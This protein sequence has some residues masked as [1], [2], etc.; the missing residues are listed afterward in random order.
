MPGN[1]LDD[2]SVFCSNE[3][4]LGELLDSSR[5]FGSSPERPNRDEELGP[6]SPIS[7]SFGK[8]EGL[9]M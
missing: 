5:I 9:E 6:F 1:P 8:E 4:N 7:Q 2:G 3:V